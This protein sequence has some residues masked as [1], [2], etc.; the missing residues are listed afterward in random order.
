MYNN[1][2]IGAVILAA[3]LSSRMGQPKQLMQLAGKP[4]FLYSVDKAIT[5]NLNPI[6]VVTGKYHHELTDHL[7]SRKN[8]SILNNE[9]YAEG[10]ATS[11]RK[12]IRSI[13][14]NNV[15]AAFVM[16]ADQPFIPLSLIDNMIQSYLE[17][18]SKG[19]LIFQPQYNSSPG[20]PVLFDSSLFCE[21]RQLEGDVGGKEILQKYK[22]Q[23][24]RVPAGDDSW[25]FDIDN[26]TDY[27]KAVQMVKNEMRE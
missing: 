15:D 17:N 4:L 14:G 26:P 8:V 7:G 18:R 24:K 2:K 19:Y 22:N 12:G 23:I 27:E 13:E 1:V 3:G 20:H 16:L 10:M 25:N 21:F 9:E 6:A 5:A 11:L